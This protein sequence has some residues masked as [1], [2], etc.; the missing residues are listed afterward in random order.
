MDI[1][2]DS[3][4]CSWST[5]LAM[6]SSLLK[7]LHA[8]PDVKLEVLVPERQHLPMRHKLLSSPSLHKLDFAVHG[9][10]W[11]SEPASEFG[12]FKQ[13]IMKA[14]SLKSLT[15]RVSGF[16]EENHRGRSDVAD[17]ELNLQFGPD[18]RFPALEEL[19]LDCYDKY[20]LS[21]AHCEIWA[22]CMD[23]NH[24]KSL[25]LGHATPQY[26]LPAITGRVPNLKRLRF[27]FWRN[28]HG[29]KASWSSSQDLTIVTDFVQSIE[30]LQELTF[31]SWDDVECSQLRPAILATHGRSLRVLRHELYFRDAWKL[32]HFEDLQVK[33]SILE[34]LSVTIAME[35]IQP[36][37]NSRTRWPVSIQQI[38]CSMRSLRHLTLRIHLR[39]DS[40]EFVPIES[41]W[42][43]STI[44]DDS[45]RRV[46][47]SLYNGFGANA[48]IERV[49]VIFWAVTPGQILWTYT[50]ER[51]WVPSE[52]RYM[53]VVDKLI[54]GE[55]LDWQARNEPFDP[56]G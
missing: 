36:H 29:P 6:P 43:R 26:L 5:H 42:E 16:G 23:W 34:E 8:R 55:T 37:P 40:S 28:A 4:G 35:E 20:Y 51:R 21:A 22:E 27:G 44:D 25:D 12:C 9:T 33:A 19:T 7:A 52:K 56:W 11:Q 14:G 50:A 31:F 10:L 17:G 18:D 45:A 24:L 49:T 38:L 32:E 30:A 53:L 46:V 41:S 1:S 39:H 3:D 48:A 54:E 2:T 13:L 47:T 15:L